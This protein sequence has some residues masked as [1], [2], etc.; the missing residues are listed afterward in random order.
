MGL[1]DFLHSHRPSHKIKAQLLDIT[2]EAMTI[3][4]AIGK[5]SDYPWLQSE[6][7]P[8]RAAGVELVKKLALELYNASAKITAIAINVEAEE[9]TKLQDWLAA[10]ERVARIGR[11]AEVAHV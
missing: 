1:A 10:D 7:A 9:T 2:H 11:G 5:M 6:P 3:S 4:M 8:I